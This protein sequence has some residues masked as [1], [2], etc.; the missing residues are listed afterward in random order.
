MVH[1]LHSFLQNPLMDSWDAQLGRDTWCAH[2]NVPTGQLFPQGWF[3]LY[4]ELHLSS[5]SFFSWSVL[6]LG[7]VLAS[8]WL[9]YS[10][11]GEARPLWSLFTWLI[12][13][14]PL[15]LEVVLQLLPCNITETKHAVVWGNLCIYLVVG[16]KQH[17]GYCWYLRSLT[18]VVKSVCLQWVLSSGFISR[19]VG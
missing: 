2:S 10:V 15:N 4:R 9:S 6:V 5:Q 11:V 14:F 16:Y 7:I 19:L 8:G 13:P 17:W 12:I 1:H 18:S 3:S